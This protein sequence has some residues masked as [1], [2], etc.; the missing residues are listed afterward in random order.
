MKGRDKSWLRLL[1][2]SITLL[3]FTGFWLILSVPNAWSQDNTVNYTLSELQ[4]RDFSNKNLEGTSFAGADMQGANFRRANL[5]ATILTKGSFLQADLAG[6]NLAEAFADRVN[7][8][9]AD[10]T[11]AIFTDA[12]LT[13]SRFFD[14]AIAGAD[15]SGAIIDQ[16]QVNLMCEHA[17]GINPVTG[18]STRE[19]LGCRD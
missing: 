5:Q 3:C 4:Y 17:D 12:I 9:E 11:N 1:W 18:V 19:S 15:F 16:Y 13:S 2:G 7:F 8:N 10:L 14:A 6:A